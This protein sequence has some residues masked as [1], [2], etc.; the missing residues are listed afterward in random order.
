MPFAG[1]VERVAAENP[2][3]GTGRIVNQ[4]RPCDGRG[5]VE[6]SAECEDVLN[7]TAEFCGAGSAQSQKQGVEG[8]PVTNF[9]LYTQTFYPKA[10]PGKQNESHAHS[11]C[12]RP[13]PT[14][15]SNAQSP[16]AGA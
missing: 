16:A 14:R 10:S 13:I 11:N 15:F 9:S 12:A 8:P 3:C 5:E 6:E 7:K 4:Q 2:G 1:F